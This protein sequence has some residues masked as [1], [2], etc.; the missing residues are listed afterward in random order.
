[1][2]PG[3]AG[4]APRRRGPIYTRAMVCRRRILGF[5]IG[6]GLVAAAAAPASAGTN[7]A[8]RYVLSPSDVG[9]SY[10]LNASVS[11]ARTLTDI[12]VGD[13]AAIQSQIRHQ[14]LGGE[15]AAYN[16]VSVKWGIVSIA[17]VFRSAQI[18]DIVAAWEQDTVTTIVGKRLALPHGAPGRHGALIR[19]HVVNQPLLIY[20]WQ[21]GRTIASV[22]VTGGTV[23]N[24]QLSLVMKLARQQ[25]AKIGS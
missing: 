9:R 10:K 16:G 24:A 8:A 13:S 18:T 5:A 12:V 3:T 14:W 1:M 21:H 11:G 15:Q 17:D 7:P 20:M 23:G 19:G 25:D 2:A 6:L 4:A 22:D